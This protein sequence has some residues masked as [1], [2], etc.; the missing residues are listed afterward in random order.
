MRSDVEMQDPAPSMLDHKE[1]IQELKTPR[2]H[3][4][5]IHSD[6]H[7]AM[8]G[9]EGEPASGGIAATPRMSQ[10][11]GYGALRDP[12]ADLQELAMDLRSAPGRILHC[13]PTNQVSDLLAHFWSA[14]GWARSPSP[15][16][17]EACPMP[18]DHGL[19]FH[20]NQHIRPSRPDLLQGGPEQT[21]QAVQCRPRPFPF[22]DSNLLPEG[23]D[24]Q[25]QIGTT[26]EEDADGR[27]ECR[28]D[29]EHDSTFVATRHSKLRTGIKTG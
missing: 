20:D 18:T 29:A 27:Q 13:Q 9:E 10:I 22:E 3:G 11:P 24:F 2:G 16:Q 23:E 28:Y 4:K 8:I 25:C 12:E 5:E 17:A 19:R 1:T 14:A 7:F 21:I 26:A 6:D 15:E